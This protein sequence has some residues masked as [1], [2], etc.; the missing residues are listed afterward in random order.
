M[1]VGYRSQTTENSA[2]SQRLVVLPAPVILAGLPGKNELI[3]A[4][5]LG[6]SRRTGGPAFGLASIDGQQDVGI[7]IQ[8]VLSDRVRVQQAV[9]LFATYPTGYPAGLSGFTAGG[10]TYQF[11]Y[12]VALSLGS[13]YGV[14]L[15]NA[16][17][18]APGFAPDNS[19][20]RYIAYQPSV[21][22]S[23]AVTSS[24]TLLLEDQIATQTAPHGP[25]GNR[26]LAGV[27]QTLS[28]NFV[29]DLDYE[30]NLKPPTGFAQHTT[31][32]G[33]ITLRL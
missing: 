9:E 1:G 32:E 10:A 2:Q 18:V 24:T 4:P 22:F 11:A 8:H 25:S 31:F 13:V 12:T 29:V 19:I 20:Q 21:T 28:P 6:F 33:G 7:G 5:P 23:I 27:Q 30:R 3:V 16:A 17:I 26:A 15:S 14:A